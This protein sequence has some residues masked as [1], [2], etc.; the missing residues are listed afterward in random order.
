MKCN[1]KNRAH[2]EQNMD[3]NRIC[4]LED[5]QEEYTILMD[6]KAVDNDRKKLQKHEWVSVVY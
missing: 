3:M 1:S 4:E 6:Y 5:M 2:K